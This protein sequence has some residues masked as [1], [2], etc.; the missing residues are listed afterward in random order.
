MDPEHCFKAVS[1]SKEVTKGFGMLA[2][3]MSGMKLELSQFQMIWERYSEIWTVDREEYVDSLAR[4]KPR[5]KDFEEE[6][7]RQGVLDLGFTY[8]R[9]PDSTMKESYPDQFSIPLFRVL[10][11]WF[12]FAQLAKGKK[13]RP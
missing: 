6:L 9:D 3:C 8:M 2:N 11:R 5:L 1:E 12:R 10:C 4:K 7:H 13:S